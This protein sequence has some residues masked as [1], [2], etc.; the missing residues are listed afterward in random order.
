MLFW[1]L[2]RTKNSTEFLIDEQIRGLCLTQNILCSRLQNKQLNSFNRIKEDATN[3][4]FDLL[5]AAYC[6]MHTQTPNKRIYF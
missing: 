4:L 5:S 1:F 6:D 2:K 3:K